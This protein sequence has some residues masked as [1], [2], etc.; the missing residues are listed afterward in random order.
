[1]NNNDQLDPVRVTQH[2]LELIVI[3]LNLCPFA[4]REYQKKRIRFKQSMACDEQALLQDLIVE[5][6]LLNR[7]AEIETTVLIVPNALSDFAEYNQFFSFVDTLIQEMELDGV[8]QVASFHPQYQFAGTQP[9]DVENYTNRAP[10]PIL[11]I[12]RETSLEHAIEQHPN[13]AQIPDDNI[14]LM[15]SLGLTHMTGLLSSCGTESGVE[16]S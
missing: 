4:K 6:S 3:G 15:Q 11:H 12:L 9:D 14:K 1:M 5:L 16:P 2:W 13:T 7:Q 10:Y 8:F